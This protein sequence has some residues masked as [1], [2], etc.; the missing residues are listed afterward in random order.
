MES[1]LVRPL[2]FTPEALPNMSIPTKMV[3]ARKVLRSRGLGGAFAAGARY[4]FPDKPRTF[5]TWQKLVANGRGL[6]IGGPSRM[7]SSQGLLPIYPL[8]QQLDNCNFSRNTVWEGTIQ[9]D[10][11]FQYDPGRPKGRQYIAEAIDLSMVASRTYDFVLSCHSIEHTANP[12]KALTEWM[13]VL[14]DSGRVLLVVPHKEGSFDHRRPVTSLPHLIED[15]KRNTK[16][17]DMTHLSEILSLHDVDRDWGVAD[18]K[19]FEE[20]ARRNPENRC[21]HQH[22]FNTQLVLEILNHLGLQVLSTEAL[23]PFHI[24]VAAEKLPEGQAPRNEAFLSKHA[25]WRSESPFHVDR[26]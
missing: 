23:R 12:L 24:I 9:E 1:W 3:I 21:L 16:E 4:F 6:E 20:R 17:D 11:G 22:V 18:A 7:F 10:I 19:A 15:F 13:R 25:Q 8:I 26:P 14:K 5:A 2:V